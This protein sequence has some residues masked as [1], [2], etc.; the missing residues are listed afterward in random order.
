[1]TQKK[2]EARFDVLGIQSSCSVDYVLNRIKVQDHQGGCVKSCHPSFVYLNL[3]TFFLNFIFSPRSLGKLDYH[4][5]NLAHHWHELRPGHD[6]SLLG[7]LQSI[8]P[9]FT[10]T[11]SL[12]SFGE[13]YFSSL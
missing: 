11:A 1:M 8:L 5:R 10:V 4:V 7:V 3:E 6:A 2:M 12:G 9:R 13:S